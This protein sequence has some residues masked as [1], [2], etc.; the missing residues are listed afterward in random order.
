MKQLQTT[1]SEDILSILYTA[2]TNDEL[3]RRIQDIILETGWCDGLAGAF[4]IELDS[5]LKVE[6]AIGDERSV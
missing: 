6:K 1:Q 3:V 2:E 5:A 4:L